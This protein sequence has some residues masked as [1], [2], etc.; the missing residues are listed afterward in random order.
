MKDI[1]TYFHDD[2]QTQYDIINYIF[3]HAKL[4][5]Q[6]LE[7]FSKGVKNIIKTWLEKNKELT[8]VRTPEKPRT[9]ISRINNHW[10]NR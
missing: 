7:L 6:H 5:E 1:S 9:N 3:T 4:E 2:I 10:V 8:P